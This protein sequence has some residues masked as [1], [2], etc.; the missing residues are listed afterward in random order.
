MEA[1]NNSE[2]KILVVDD[3]QSNIILLK[4]ILGKEGYQILEAN[5]GYECIEKLKTDNP[6]IILLDIM[7]PEINGLETLEIIRNAEVY[8]DIPIIF[9][10]ALDDKKDVV[11]GF[12]SGANDYV[13]KPFNNNELVVR[14]N[15]QISLIAA[16]REIEEKTISLLSTIKNRDRL[17]SVIAH[18]LRSPLSSIKMILNLLT[19]ELEESKIDNELYSMLKEANRTSEELFLLL[20]NLLKWTKT[21]TGRLNIIRQKIDIIGIINGLEDL[22]TMMTK[23]KGIKISLISD[24]NQIE[25][26]SDTD[27]IK[28][29]LRN[30]IV[31]AIKFS[32]T[33]GEIKITVE[34]INNEIIIGIIDNG[35]GISEANK[36][37]ILSKENSYTTFGT[38]NEEG[39]GLGLNLCNEF[40]TKLGGRLWFESEEGVGT[41]F[42]FTIPKV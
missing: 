10:S 41:K 20:D 19:T 39:S 38:N 36:D 12:K 28:T 16:K 21:Q 26:F 15:H 4:A 33:G 40:V 17:Y 9:L 27:L 30:L 2:Y 8:P 5:N 11:K 23:S 18:D 31:N 14:V 6:D 35:C 22:Y 13:T 29:I 7:M 3:V 25:T 1:I 37:K 24:S 32:Y 42:Y 34:V